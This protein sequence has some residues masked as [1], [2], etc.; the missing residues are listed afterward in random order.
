VTARDLIKGSLRLLGVLAGGE[1]PSADM[2]QDALSSLN[3]L[4]DSWNTERLMLY[5]ILPKPFSF[6]AGQTVYTV[7]PG[8]NVDIPRPEEID[9]IQYSYTA[10]STQPLTMVMTLLNQD[11]YN[12]IGIPSISTQLPTMAYVDDSFPQRKV[13][14]YPVPQQVYSGQMFVWTPLTSIATL[15]DA[16]SLPYGYEKALKFNLALDL[17][18]E[19]GAAA[20]TAAGL[21][22]AQANMAKAVVKSANIEVPLLQC[23]QALI[24]Q[25]DQFNWRTGGFGRS[26]T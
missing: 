21:I 12:A 25:G 6:V 8:G 15:D 14:M 9:S 7:G 3:T 11:Q 19:Y 26:G 23:D 13:Y 20:V 17:A 4:I 2:A 16:I 10:D 1:N 5:A 22:A 18:P 24:P